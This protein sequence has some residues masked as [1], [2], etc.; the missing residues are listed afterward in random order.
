M[1]GDEVG[2][3]EQVV[4]LDLLDADLGGALG[5]Q[6]RIVGDHA[7]LEPQAAGGGDRADVAATDH[8]EGLAGELDAHEPVLLPLAGLGGE[9]GGREL[10]GER[11]HE[12]DRVLGGGDRVAERRVHHDDATGGGGRDVDVVHADPGAADYLQF[13]RMLE[14]LCGDL[15]RRTDRKAVI[16]ANDFE[17][18]VLV[19]AGL[20]VD[21]NAPLL[22]D[23]DGGGGQLV[24][25]ENAGSH[26]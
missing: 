9:V 19:Q 5:A 16:V 25:D 22:E 15:G 12:G 1:K 3:G 2:A 20:H 14:Q 18:L 24:G 13:G 17:E 26:W 10:A 7:H 4:K 21:L 11:E 6:E 23:G 8:A